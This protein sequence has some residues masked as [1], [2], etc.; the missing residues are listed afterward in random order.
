[1]QDR[2]GEAI[3]LDRIL[4]THCQLQPSDLA[5]PLQADDAGAIVRRVEGRFGQLYVTFN[6]GPHNRRGIPMHAILVRTT[7]PRLLVLTL[8]TLGAGVPLRVPSP[9]AG[10]ACSPAAHGGT[11]AG[12]ASLLAGDRILIVRSFG[13]SARGSKS[14]LPPIAIC[15][16]SDAPAPPS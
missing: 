16:N 5:A 14:A 9:P 10:T 7:V 15:P 12:Q 13:G 4:V 3:A 1:M 6:T 8:G 2:F 11:Q